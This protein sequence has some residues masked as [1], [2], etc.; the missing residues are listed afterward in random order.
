MTSNE[1]YIQATPKQVFGALADGYRFSE[2]VVGAK[3][4][5][6]VAD[7]WPEPG[8]SFKHSVGIGPI[9]TSDITTVLEIQE[10]RYLLLKTRFRP[11]GTAKVR[12][13][14]EPEA[15]GTIVTMQ[16]HPDGGPISMAWNRAMDAA[17]HLRNAESLR[18]LRSMI[19]DKGSNGTQ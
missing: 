15:N 9:S 5:H 14:L 4:I 11:F 16:E 12:L 8:S 1:I 18:R 19:E 10:P 3:T 7:N 17:F 13:T 6:W 2:W